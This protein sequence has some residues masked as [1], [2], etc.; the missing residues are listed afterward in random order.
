MKSPIIIVEG[1][2]DKLILEHF[3][4]EDVLSTVDIVVAPGRTAA[5]TLARSILSS[6][7]R[8]VILLL[9]SDTIEPQRL[10]EFRE[11]VEYS[12]REAS[13]GF[14]YR[15]VLAVPTIEIL[16]IEDKNLLRALEPD[17]SVQ[18]FEL[19]FAR[20][21]PRLYLQQRFQCGT[22][23]L[24]CLSKI[25]K[26]LPSDLQRNEPPEGIIKDI[27]DFIRY[28][29]SLCEKG[30]EYRVKACPEVREQI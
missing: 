20:Q 21:N 12:L 13:S 23:Y 26:N 19:E 8:P 5:Q 9:D 6:A 29:K 22:S 16:L 11:M 15:L 14:K 25:L 10:S 27:I 24:L 3:L 30:A 1:E 17:Y 28:I 4:P 18:P 2:A 7:V